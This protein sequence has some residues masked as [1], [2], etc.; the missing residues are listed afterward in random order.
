MPGRRGLKPAAFLL[1]LTLA[2][3]ALHGYHPAVEDANIYLT[4]VKQALHPELYPFNSNFF[5]L[6]AHMTLFPQVVKTLV[7]VTHLPLDV[8][9]LLLH[10]GFIFLL[11]YAALRLAR[12]MFD[13]SRAQWGAVA[14]VAGLLTLPI[15]GTRL[16]LMDEY[17][18]PRSVSLPLVLLL[19]ADSYQKRWLRC[20]AWTVIAGC[21]HPLMIVFGITYV[22]L[23][24]V[25]ER[26]PST[27]PMPA[28]ASA[29]LLLPFGLGAP[30]TDG[31]REIL[32]ANSYFYIQR[33]E[34]YE[35]FGAF[36]PLALIAWYRHL[37]GKK[38]QRWIVRIATDTIWFGG[39]YIAGAVVIGIPKSLA[40]LTLLQPM[41]AFQIVYAIFLIMTAGFMADYLFRDKAWRWALFFIPL[42]IGMGYK[43]HDIFPETPQLELPGRASSNDWVQ[44]FSWVR[45]NTPKNA[46]FALP[47]DFMLRDDTHSF[48]AIAER[49]QLADGIKDRSAMSMFPQMAPIWQDQ[50][51]AATGWEGF[52]PADFERLKARYR[53]DWVVLEAGNTHGFA[54][55]YRNRS[56]AVC[57]LP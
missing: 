23:S 14:M 44:A 43:Q 13:S 52:Q 31:Y 51:H 53:T 42:C 41:R 18:N 29:F 9:M 39:I 30:V 19:I 17:F 2:A 21:I 8:C 20:V 24:M 36:A 22:V 33:W 38:D 34:W 56:V 32:K 1:L 4:C 37:A 28:L 46:Y 5:E 10:I 26:M 57:R 35:W 40:T 49:S 16:Y 12:M 7:V 45:E 55:P 48:R 25:L 11:L 47:P 27:A 54:C 50:A 3:I 6:H 15:A